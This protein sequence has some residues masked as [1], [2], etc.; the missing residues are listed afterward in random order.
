[1]MGYIIQRKERRVFWIKNEYLLKRGFLGTCRRG[2]SVASPSLWSSFRLGACQAL[3]LIQFHRM[4]KMEL[5]Q[6]A[7][8]SILIGVLV[9]T[10]L[11]ILSV[12][13]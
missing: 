11:F 3:P 2:F 9:Y 12:F 13:Y 10:A 1:M 6:R 5:F 7:F 8:N 4:V